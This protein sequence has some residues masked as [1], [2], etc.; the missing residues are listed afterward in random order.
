MGQFS[1]MTKGHQKH[2]RMQHGFPIR[3]WKKIRER[4]E[5]LDYLVYA[6]AGLDI[7]NPN[8]ERLA[9]NMAKV[10]E[11]E[12]EETNPVPSSPKDAKPKTQRRLCGFAV[13][14]GH[15]GPLPII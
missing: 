14:L 15:S 8:F 13:D 2:T 11:L 5:A 12:P 6:L 9:E 4:N 1:F 3:Y 7:L 10:E